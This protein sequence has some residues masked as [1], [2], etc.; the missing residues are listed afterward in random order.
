M[1]VLIA[2][3]ILALCCCTCAQQPRRQTTL[4]MT[5]SGVNYEYI[6]LVLAAGRDAKYLVDVG[7]H[8]TIINGVPE[9][10]TYIGTPYI[11]PPHCEGHRGRDRFTVFMTDTPNG[12][13]VSASLVNPYDVQGTCTSIP[14]L[15]YCT[16]SYIWCTGA[17]LSRGTITISISVC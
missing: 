14:S 3:S 13:A 11:E 8:Q 5:L 6:G 7:S 12:L 17:G 4:Q 9:A 2:L 16:I 10:I 15:S 1:R